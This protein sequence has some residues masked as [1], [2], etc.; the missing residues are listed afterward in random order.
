MKTKLIILAAV[1]C[2]LPSCADFRLAGLSIETPWGSAT[3]DAKGATVVTLKP[4]VIDEK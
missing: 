3:T 4:I 1:A 2:F